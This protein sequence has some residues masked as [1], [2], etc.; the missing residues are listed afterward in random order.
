MSRVQDVEDVRFCLEHAIGLKNSK[1]V[2]LVDSERI[3]VVGGSHGGFLTAHLIGQYPELFKAAALRNPV[4]NIPAMFS[5]TDI[6]DWCYVETAGI[7]SYDFDKFSVPS[8]DDLLKAYERSPIRYVGNVKTPTIL[9]LGGK[10]RRVPCSQGIEYYHALVSRRVP[11]KMLYFPEDTHALDKPC[12]EAEQWV[13]TA[14]F[15]SLHL[16]QR[17][18]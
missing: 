13:A 10:D 6:P 17:N 9:L 4:T 7:G 18:G 11:T 8:M 1:H 5:S 12:S 16:S 14:D 2:S 15:I 3:C